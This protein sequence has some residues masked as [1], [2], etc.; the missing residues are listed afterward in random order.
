M[1]DVC[2]LRQ[3]SPVFPPCR[4]LPLPLGGG[5]ADHQLNIG[6][7]EQSAVKLLHKPQ[8]QKNLDRPFHRAD[9]VAGE[10]GDHLRRVGDM[11]V[12]L[13]FAA[14]FQGFQVQL[15]QDIR[16]QYPVRHTFQQHDG[17]PVEKALFQLEV[18]IFAVICHWL[19]LLCAGFSVCVGAVVK[20]DAPFL[21]TGGTLKHGSPF[22]W[23]GAVLDPHPAAST[24][25]TSSEGKGQRLPGSSACSRGC[26]SGKARCRRCGFCG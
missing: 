20:H 3:Q 11:L 21:C 10:G 7:V 18:V 8:L 23:M 19:T 15:H 22:P 6:H 5:L 1:S 16:E 12:K 25:W 9:L 24:V 4:P 26:S 13:Q 14:V 2:P 17:I